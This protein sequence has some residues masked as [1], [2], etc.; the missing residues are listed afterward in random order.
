MIASPP[1]FAYLSQPCGGGAA[2]RWRSSACWWPL[3]PSPARQSWG[4][5]ASP[6]CCICE[7]SGRSLARQRSNG[8]KPMPRSARRS[9]GCVRTR[10]TW[11]LSPGNASCSSSPTR[12]S[13]GFW[14]RTARPEARRSPFVLAG[15]ELLVLVQVH[16]VFELRLVRH[17]DFDE[18]AFVERIFVHDARVILELGVHGSDG[19]AQR[20]DQLLDRPDRL[21]LTQRLALLDFVA[22]VRH[23]DGDDLTELGLSILRDAHLSAIPFDADPQV[24]LG[25]LQGISHGGLPPRRGH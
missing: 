4:R 6:V 16:Q 20:R 9:R 18:P 15:G 19:T 13:T 21:D 12:W 2:A 1:R 7:P 3:L 8:C 5:T 25:E 10:N 17:L 14:T 11:K 22:D 23:L 24:V